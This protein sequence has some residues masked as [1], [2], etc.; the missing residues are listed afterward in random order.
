MKKLNR[1][2]GLQFLAG[3]A[4]LTVAGLSQAQYVWVNDKGVK[5]FSDR[6]PP[7]SIPLK[8]ILK[9]PGGVQAASTASAD[10]A[11]KPIVAAPPPPSLADREADYRKR[12]LAKADEDKKAA[13]DAKN[14]AYNKQRCDTSRA[15]KAALDSGIR[16]RSGANG[17]VMDDA[18]RQQEAAKIKTSLA[19]C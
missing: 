4:L 17:D 19:E 13:A 7:A 11:P 12:Q 5:Q 14:A 10:V 2:R 18:Q 1:V 3:A 8:N 16:I 9:A 6:A 15:A